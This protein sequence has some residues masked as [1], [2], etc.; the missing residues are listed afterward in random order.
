MLSHIYSTN[1]SNINF[2]I[3]LSIGIG[4]TDLLSLLA[5]Q[6]LIDLVSDPLHLD[7]LKIYLMVLAVGF[8]WLLKG[9]FSHNLLYQV[10]IIAN[11]VKNGLIL[12]MYE[13]TSSLSQHVVDAQ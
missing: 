3:F 5:L 7:H 12:M 2:I 8:L 6:Y 1:R 10:P 9:C 13:K 4:L 11:I